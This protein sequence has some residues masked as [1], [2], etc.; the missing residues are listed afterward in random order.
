M[1][2]RDIKQLEARLPHGNRTR[3]VCSTCNVEKPLGEFY[4]RLTGRS[5]GLRTGKCRE[6]TRATALAWN[7]Q[8]RAHVNQLKREHL[9]KRKEA[10]NV[11]T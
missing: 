10:N 6:C 5:A 7:N 11:A 2:A 9:R 1:I 4:M 3:N 8:N